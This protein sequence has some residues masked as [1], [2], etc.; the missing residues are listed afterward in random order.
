MRALFGFFF[1]MAIGLSSVSAEEIL[2][3]KVVNVIDGNTFE[4]IAEDNE[5]YKIC[6]LY[7]S[8]SPRD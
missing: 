2:K 3:G 6:L 7:T 1:L 5:T 4:M 8:P